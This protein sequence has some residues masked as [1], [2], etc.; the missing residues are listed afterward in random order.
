MEA[1]IKANDETNRNKIIAQ[2]WMY[3]TNTSGNARPWRD[4]WRTHNGP[5]LTSCG[6]LAQLKISG[7][8]LK[9]NETH[10]VYVACLT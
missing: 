3:Y 9:L 10:I 6:V 5:L 4:L 7:H 8:N 2:V 1:Q